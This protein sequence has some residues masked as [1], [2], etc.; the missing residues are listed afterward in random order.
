MIIAAVTTEPDPPPAASSY[1]DDAV[2]HFAAVRSRLL[3][4][5]HRILGSWSDAEDVVQ[6]AWLRWQLSDRTTVANPTAFL[7]TTA[8]RLAINAAQSARVRRETY[9]G[10]RL[11]ERVAM[12]DD[13]ALDIEHHEALEQGMFLLFERLGPAERAAYVLHEAFDYPY[14]QIAAIVRTTEA[15]ARQ[16]ASRARKHLSTDRRRSADS[17]ERRLLLQ[18]FLA[19]AK[20]G[21]I[22]ELEN[23]LAA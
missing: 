5:V 11:P 12:G 19:A 4:I 9:V 18:A 16:L 14:P 3:G 8:T 15:N 13:P 2:A 1:L 7:V 10:S 23:L 20:H 17:S 6:D 22:H 21:D